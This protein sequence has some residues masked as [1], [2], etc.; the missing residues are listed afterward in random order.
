[1]FIIVGD[2][3][4]GMFWMAIVLCRHSASR[5]NVLLRRGLR[6]LEGNRIHLARFLHR[7]YEDEI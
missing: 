1:M 5:C 4:N 7:W 2:C 3:Q 6:L